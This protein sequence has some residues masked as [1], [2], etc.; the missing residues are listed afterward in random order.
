MT[1]SERMFA[2]M[3]AK[4]IK[5]ADLAR[6]LNIN[7]TVVSAWKNRNSNP[8]VEYTVQICELLGISIEFYITGKEINNISP[9]E[10]K[11]LEAYRNALPAIQM[12]TKKLLDVQEPEQNQKEPEQETL[13]TSRTG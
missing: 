2:I 11:I 12:A 3:Q 8:A 4:N 7:K 10:Q 13:S 6:H 9:E 5:L 1:I